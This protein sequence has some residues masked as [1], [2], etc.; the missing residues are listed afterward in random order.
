MGLGE[1]NEAWG[2]KNSLR[3]RSGGNESLQKLT[4]KGTGKRQE[5][6]MSR[7]REPDGLEKRKGCFF[8]PEG[9]EGGGDGAPEGKVYLG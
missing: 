6:G 4:E 8:A 1:W 3:T 9:T 5:R 7:G 2:G